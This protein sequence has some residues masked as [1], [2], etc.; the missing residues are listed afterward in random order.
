LAFW[1]TAAGSAATEKMRINSAGNVGIGTS[2][3]A[4]KLHASQTYVVPSTGGISA[5]T[6]GIFSNNSAASANANVSILSRS[7]GYQRL[8][9]GNQTVENSQYIESFGN[10]GTTGY[11]AFGV[12]SSSGT[13]AGTERMRIDSAGNVGIGTT[14][15]TVKLDVVGAINATTGIFGGTF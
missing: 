4:A 13:T 15:P 10:G 14:A 9:F 3:P 6:I 1:T 5:D 7:S 8:Y 12:S 11:L 2:S